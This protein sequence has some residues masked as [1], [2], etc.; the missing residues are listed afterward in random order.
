MARNFGEIAYSTPVKEM[1]EKLG[2]R[3]SY[4]RM[5][6]ATYVDGLTP[7]EADFI[8]RRDSFYMASFGENGYPYIQ[9]RGGPKGFL[10]VLDP[11]RLGF[12][13]FKGN[14][15][16][17]TVGN[18]ATNN[19]VALI[20]VDYPAKARLKIYARAEILEFKDNQGLYQ[21]LDLDGYKFRPERMMVL[22]VEAYDWN[23]PQHITPKYTAEEIEQA[24][25]PQRNHI[26]QLE[27]EIARLKKELEDAK[28]GK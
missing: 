22:N 5:E 2:S 26:E 12:I 24:F 13:D 4:A 14:M 18:M 27:A 19:N 3:A 6:K 28:G 20:L 7:V 15:Q 10:K 25:A 11:K 23:C 8:A 16:Y 17:I 1:Q 9:H 21:Q